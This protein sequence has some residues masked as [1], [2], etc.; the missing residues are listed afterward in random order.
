MGTFEWLFRCSS[1][2]FSVLIIGDVTLVP[3]SLDIYMCH[4]IVQD[5]N[6]WICIYMPLEACYGYAIA[7]PI[8]CRSP[9]SI[10]SLAGKA[11]WLLISCFWKSFWAVA[12]TCWVP[13]WRLK[14]LEHFACA[15]FTALTY[16]GLNGIPLEIEW[17]NV[18][19]CDNFVGL[20]VQLF[21]AAQS[22]HDVRWTSLKKCHA[23]CR[24]VTPKTGTN[25]I[26]NVCI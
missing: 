22:V 12:P 1:S 6:W 26:L 23:L 20:G 3:W 21:S 16:S 11:S 19:V 5:D 8:D 17:M 4:G 13:L 10:D 18:R 25:I 7:R 2:D 9:N 24:N 14:W 15:G